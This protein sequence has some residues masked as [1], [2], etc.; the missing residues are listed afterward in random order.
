MYKQSSNVDD[1]EKDQ[2]MVK[3]EE[4]VNLTFAL[5][6][7]NNFAKA[8]SLSDR[9]MLQMSADIPLAVEYKIEEMGH[10][11]FYLAPKIEEGDS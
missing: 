9:V 11:R 7:L 1:E 5:R 10:L 3:V 8:S 2:I 6:Y 4:E